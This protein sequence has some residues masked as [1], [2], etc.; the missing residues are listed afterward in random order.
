TVPASALFSSGG[1]SR[2]HGLNG[3][4]F[5]T[6]NWDGKRHQPRELTYPSSGQLVGEIP[7]N[8][9]PLFTRVD[10]QVDFNW[11]DGSPRSDLKDDD[12]GVRWTGFLAAPVSGKYQIGRA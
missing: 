2:A 5:A 8:P 7:D 11:W 1:A 6:S 10:P 9:K 12:F 3:E 4:Y